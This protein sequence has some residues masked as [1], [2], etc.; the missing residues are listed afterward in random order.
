MPTA[1]KICSTLTRTFELDRASVSEAD[2][3]VSLSFSSEEPVD[4]HFGVEILDHS[5]GSMDLSRLNN[6]APLLFNH[7]P[8]RHIGVVESATVASGRGTAVVRFADDDEGE[9][10]FRRVKTGISR[11]VSVGYRFTDQNK[12][13]VTEDGG[14]EIYR[15]RAWQPYEV[16]LVPIPA[17]DTVGVGR[18]QTT[19]NQDFELPMKRTLLHT[20]DAPAGLPPAPTVDARKVER[21]RSAELRK[22][23]K[24]FRGR[25][26][27]VDDLVD[28]AI[29][30]ETEVADFQRTLL[31]KLST[32]PIPNADEPITRTVSQP[33]TIT[34][35]RSLGE[36]YVRSPQFKDF[37]NKRTGKFSIEIPGLLSEHMKRA[38][39]T[40][41]GLTSIQK[42][43]GVIL[44]DTQPLRVADLFAQGTTASTTI[45][46]TS[47]SSITNAATAVAEE[48]Q[49]P[50]ATFAL[51]EADVA[52]KKLAVVG[53]VSDESLQDYE[54][55]QSYVNSRLLWMIQQLEDT[56][57][58]NGA[59]GNSIT[60]IL[61]VGGIQTEAAAASATLADAIHKAITKVAS[62]PGFVQQPDSIVI[63]PTDW[64]TLVLTRDGNNQYYVGGPFTGQ[65]GA[66]GIQRNGPWGLTPVVTTAIAQGT[67][68]V[69]AFKVGAQIFRKSGLMI[70]S[71]NSDASDF[72]YNR[73]AIRAEE[74]LCLVPWRPKAF[75]K[76][77]GIN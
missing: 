1:K 44:V 76:I 62:T 28:A 21:E 9:K 49:K 18:S 59:G 72:V 37:A 23:G 54:Y 30:K 55:M 48:G 61:S 4:R 39:L 24:Q 75:C 29:E 60:G 15:F 8:N 41:S 16:S 35:V 33:G 42:V 13:D 67:A 19:T 63:H 43:P 70:E 56:E 17:D 69:G 45:R 50:E 66:G 53:R 36:E 3:T 47:E 26:S 38:T 31:S 51:A 34:E 11:K 20:P 14:R 65:Y 57:L 22:L 64:Q 12:V 7:D 27:D 68:L 2:R 40:T 5:P 32:S 6:G 25:I 74:R 46:Y 77:T 10:Y 58:L 52:V 73:I 71:T